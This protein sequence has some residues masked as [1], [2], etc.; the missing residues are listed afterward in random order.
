MGVIYF[1]KDSLG[2]YKIGFSKNSILKRKKQLET[3]CSIDLQLIYEF[4]TKHKRK[5]ETSLHNLFKHKRINREFYEL[6]LDD[7]NNLKNL[8]ESFEK[9]FDVLFS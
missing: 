6:T 9:A 7:E 3:A 5:I 1:L 8:C 2:Y 4:K